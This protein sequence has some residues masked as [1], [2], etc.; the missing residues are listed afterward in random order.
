MKKLLMRVWLINIIGGLFLAAS[1][2][3]GLYY[4]NVIPVWLIVIFFAMVGLSIAIIPSIFV[5]RSIAIPLSL[6]R[7][8]LTATQTDGDLC[9][10][11]EELGSAK[12]AAVAYNGLM[13]NM[14]SI[15][16][17]ILFNSKQVG[18]SSTHLV[19]NAKGIADSSMQQFESCKSAKKSMSNMVAGVDSVL[20][21]AN[22]S[23]IISKDAYDRSLQGGVIVENAVQQI[24]QLARSVEASA[25]VVEKLG[26]KT[27]AISGIVQM[28]KEIADQTNLL[29]LNAA[30]EAA[31]AGEQGRGFAVVADEVRKLAERTATATSEIG[32][33]IAGIVSETKNAITSIQSGSE[34]AKDSAD[35]ALQAADALKQINH[36]ALET[37]E[38]VEEIARSVG[39]QHSKCGD[40][41]GSVDHIMSMADKNSSAAKVTASEAEKLSYMANNL[42]EVGTI[43]KLGQKGKESLSVH[44]GM[45]TIVQQAAELIGKQFE[46]AIASGQIKADDLFDTKYQPIAGSKP[47]KYHTRYD[48]FADKLLPSLQE[49]ILGKS[50]DIAYAICTS[51]KGYVPT[52]NNRFCQ[53]LTGDEKIDFVGNRT[54]RLFTD[55]VGKRCGAHELPF[56]LQT[57]QRDTGEI[58]HDISAP[59]YVNGKHW[60]GFRI[61]YKT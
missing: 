57:Y 28:I 21:R 54:K 52:H 5:Q 16:T 29:A 7:N 9:R 42:E 27:Q 35:L 17:R 48:A 31:R 51:P 53:P 33:V 46:L 3:G 2:I 50:T 43:F 4:S 23:R 14:H 10:K 36:G 13:A 12:L 1:S 15:I 59:I 41:I 47:Q 8:T 19:S 44:E 30:I 60:G 45:P 20:Q 49:P 24:N 11:A 32:S 25:N 40:I 56:L 55:P 58:M 37:M 18:D 61:G 26:E 38:K 22:E 34:Q 6:L 39:E